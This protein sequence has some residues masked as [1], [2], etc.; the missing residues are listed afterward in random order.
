[1]VID[2]HIYIEDQDD[3][4]VDIPMSKDAKKLVE[5][6]K[7]MADEASSN[8][9]ELRSTKAPDSVAGIP[10][11]EQNGDGVT[12]PRWKYVAQTVNTRELK[13]K[14]TKHRSYRNNSPAD[15]LV[16]EDGELR[17]ATLKDVKLTSWKPVRNV[18]E[19]TYSGAKKGWLDRTVRG[20]QSSWGMAPP[21]AQ[22]K[23]ESAEASQTTPLRDAVAKEVANN[24]EFSEENGSSSSADNTSSSSEG[25]SSDDDNDN[26]N[27]GEAEPNEPKD[28]GDTEKQP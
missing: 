8:S 20:K 9:T 4:T 21:R 16:E 10:W 26:G 22:P 7:K 18:L 12:R 27:D 17:V 1:M 13:K 5:A 24:K 11:P 2:G 3:D 14:R 23:K 6:K 19:H 15:T 28:S 25:S